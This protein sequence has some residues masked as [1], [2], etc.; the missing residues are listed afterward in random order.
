[1][2]LEGTPGWI[3]VVCESQAM[4]IWLVRAIVVEN[5][6]AR[7]EDPVLYRPAGPG[8]S[9]EGAIKSV[10]T[11]LAK[12]HHYWIGH[13]WIEHVTAASAPRAAL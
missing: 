7:R 13:V 4:A 11:T 2:L 10:V 3:G 1:V 9:L 12:T 5:V 8:F 6:I